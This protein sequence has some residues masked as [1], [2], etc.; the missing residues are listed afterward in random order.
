MRGKNIGE[1]VFLG[2]RLMAYAGEK[3][4]V[5]RSSFPMQSV[6]KCELVSGKINDLKPGMKVYKYRKEKRK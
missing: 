6:T 1:T 4:L 3:L 5:L 2:D